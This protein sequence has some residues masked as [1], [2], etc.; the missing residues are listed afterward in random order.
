[1]DRKAMLAPR[2]LPVLPVPEESPA[3][4]DH[5]DLQVFPEFK[6]IRVTLVSLEK[7]E[8]VCNNEICFS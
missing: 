7:R 3:I 2:E 8:Q 6:A 4:L 1:M 5:L